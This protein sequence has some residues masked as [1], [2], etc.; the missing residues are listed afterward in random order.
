MNEVTRD[1]CKKIDADIEAATKG[2][3]QVKLGEI[4]QPYIEKYAKEAGL[5][6]IDLFVDYMDHVSITSKQNAMNK[7][8][9]LIF[10]EN[11]LENPNFRLY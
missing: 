9:E 7:Q 6:P 8:G 4:V 3:E 2:Q 11:D 1:I 5:D 10:G